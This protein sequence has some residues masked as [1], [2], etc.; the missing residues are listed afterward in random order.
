MTVFGDEKAAWEKLNNINTRKVELT[1]AINWNKIEDQTDLDVWNRQVG[2]FWVPEKVPLSNDLPQWRELTHAERDSIVKV[3]AGL[4]LLDTIQSKMGAPSL[5]KDAVTDHEA[6]VYDAFTFMEAVH[7]KSYSSI[8]ATFISSVENERAFEF[9]AVNECL[10][11]KAAIVESYY[12]ADDPEKKKI[13]SVLLESFLFYSGFFTP[14]WYSSHGK[15]TNVG[16]LI[17]LILRDEALHGFYIGYKFRLAYEKSSKE[18]QEELLSFTHELLNMLYHNELR[19][20]EELY[21]EVG[22]TDEVKPYLRY[23]ANKALMNLGFDPVFTAEESRVRPEILAS[24]NPAAEDNH[25]FFSGSGSS[26]VVKH[27]GGDDD[28]AFSDEG[29]DD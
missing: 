8:F 4:T 24:M 19:Y 13:I 25:D 15:L 14:F 7:A 16:D 12:Q 23:N 26:Y 9:A 18:R 27:G 29:W 1:T 20:T 10:Q 5:I 6:A 3:F 2:N 11:R 22:L 17:R 28:A 21:N